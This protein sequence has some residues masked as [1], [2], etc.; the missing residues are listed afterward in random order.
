MPLRIATY[1]DLSQIALIL[2]KAFHNDPLNEYFFPNRDK[3][4]DDYLRDY[5]HETTTSWWKYDRVWIVN[6]DNDDDGGVGV[7]GVICWARR[8]NADT[9]LWNV[10]GWWDPSK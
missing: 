6:D 1:T 9:P 3:Y 7:N 8:G 4:P 5:L 10:P 2:S